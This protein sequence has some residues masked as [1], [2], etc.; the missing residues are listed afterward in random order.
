MRAPSRSLDRSMLRSRRTWVSGASSGAVESRTSADA[1]IDESGVRSSCE[2]SE[3]NCDLSR[4][5]S[6]SCSR[7]WTACW[8]SVALPSATAAWAA[9]TASRRASWRVNRPWR[10]FETRST[11][12]VPTE[13]SGTASTDCSSS[14][15][16]ERHGSLTV[17]GGVVA[18]VG[19]SGLEDGHVG[20]PVAQAEAEPPEVGGRDAERRWAARPASHRA[21][22]AS[23]RRRARPP[24]G[25]PR[26]GRFAP[27]RLRGRRAPRQPR[28]LRRVG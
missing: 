2:T 21:G 14:A 20:A 26:A 19:P 23:R 3:R 11:P 27:R 22:R 5:S 17:T 18:D 13:R 10:L 16:A 7:S 1:L 9:K 25:R 12:S 8:Y 6:L 28:W 15:R 24:R 4:S